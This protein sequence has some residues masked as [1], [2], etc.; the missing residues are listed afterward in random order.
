M[1]SDLEQQIR[2]RAYDIWT[3]SGRVE[4]CAND[5]WLEAERLVMMERLSAA[6]PYGKRV[7]ARRPKSASNGKRATRRNAA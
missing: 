5:H 2:D 6:P 1:M 7:T 3:L 4:G